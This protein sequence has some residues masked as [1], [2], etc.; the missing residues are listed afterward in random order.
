MNVTEIQQALRDIGWPVTVDGVAGGQTRS[1]VWDLQAGFAFRPLAI[2]GQAGPQ[3]QEA[4][5]ECLDKGGKCSAYFAFREFKSK[6]NGWIKIARMH[7]F[8]L[9]R[10]REQVGPVSVVSGYRDPRYNAGLKGAAT[11]SRHVHGDGTDVPG[12]RSQ[13]QV[14]AM[15]LFTGIGTVRSSGLVVHVDS[16]PGDPANP[17]LWYYG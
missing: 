7:A 11:N 9:D 12:V 8:R 15:G 14:R 1:A 13:G 5:R 6:G 10:Y 16:R 17:T 3:T 2:D 4:L